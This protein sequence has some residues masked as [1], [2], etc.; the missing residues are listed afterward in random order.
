MPGEHVRVVR[1]LVHQLISEAEGVWSRPE[2][3]NVMRFFFE[4]E[5]SSTSALCRC[6]AASPSASR[7]ATD[8]S[9]NIARRMKNP[10]VR[11]ALS[12][13]SVAAAPSTG[14]WNYGLPTRGIDELPIRNLLVC[15]VPLASYLNC[16]GMPCVVVLFVLCV[17][18]KRVV[19][20]PMSWRI[21]SDAASVF[22]CFILP[23]SS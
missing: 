10:S 12:S 8:S 17:F 14:V 5:M 22:Y 11:N 20:L 15:R 4:I 21:R 23:V 16:A 9:S 6:T 1:V 18:W 19:G 3:T 2:F 7:P 13:S